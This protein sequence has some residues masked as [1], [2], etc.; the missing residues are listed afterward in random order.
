M[1]S[2]ADAGDGGSGSSEGATGSEK[3]RS[4]GSSPRNCAQ[5]TE[6]KIMIEEKL[7]SLPECVTNKHKEAE[8]TENVQETTSS[9]TSGSS[10]AATSSS[11][12]D[13]EKK[14]SAWDDVK[15]REL[16]GIFELKDEASGNWRSSS[17]T[18]PQEGGSMA[19]LGLTFQP[20]KKGPSRSEGRNGECRIKSKRH[21]WTGGD[22]TPSSTMSSTTMQKH[23]SSCKNGKQTGTQ[24]TRTEVR[25]A[26]PPSRGGTQGKT[27]RTRTISEPPDKEVK[28]QGHDHS[29]EG[30][31]RK[32]SL[33]AKVVGCSGNKLTDSD[34]IAPEQEECPSN[35]GLLR[36]KSAGSVRSDPGLSPLASPGDGSSPARGVEEQPDRPAVPDLTQYGSTVLESRTPGGRASSTARRTRSPV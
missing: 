24:D 11:D 27:N 18:S 26:A 13:S 10:T 30:V 35:S 34:D 33:P 29:T 23:H 17:L 12:S 14:G 28:G 4:G 3:R 20:S 9:G 8:P 25:T 7:Q 15:V 5:M 21:T 2:R 36:Q 16:V 6:R 19:E 1:L 22:K 31:E 32:T